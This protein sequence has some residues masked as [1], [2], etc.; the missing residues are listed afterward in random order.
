MADISSEDFKQPVK[1]PNSREANSNP[2]AFSTQYNSVDVENK[3]SIEQKLEQLLMLIYFG[4]AALLAF[5]FVLSLFGANK[6]SLFVNF[7]FQLT[8]P[9][10]FP[11]E[12][13]FGR[14]PAVGA[15]VL[16]FEVIV[17][18]VVYAIVF[19]GLGRLVRIVFK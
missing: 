19:V 12:G 17:A 8:T 15:Y 14:E 16:E 5:R 2:T 10:M 11:F 13:M 3:V 4:I 7:V 6:E 18:L 9:F 1:V